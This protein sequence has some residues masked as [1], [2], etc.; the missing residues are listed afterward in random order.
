MTNGWHYATL[1]T[2]GDRILPTSCKRLDTYWPLV[3]I[4]H[5]LVDSC[6]YVGSRLSCLCILCV[7]CVVC[8]YVCVCVWREW[9]AM[10]REAMESVKVR[11]RSSMNRVFAKDYIDVLSNPTLVKLLIKQGLNLTSFWPNSKNPNAS[12]SFCSPPC[13]GYLSLLLVIDRSNEVRAA[14]CISY[15]FAALS[16]WNLDFFW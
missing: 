10:A 8:L 12:I 1:S 13:I 7:L 14:L 9:A 2:E 5:L 16:L 6:I 3:Y 4:P 15:E 11:R